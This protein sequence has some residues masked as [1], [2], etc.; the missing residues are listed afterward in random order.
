MD[1][2]YFVY[3]FINWYTFGLFL[4]FG[5]ENL[6]ADSVYFLYSFFFLFLKLDFS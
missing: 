6:G 5:P 4:L 2:P 3:P 1:M